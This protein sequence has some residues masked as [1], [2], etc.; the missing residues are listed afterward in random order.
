MAKS[1]AKS[2]GKSKPPKP[3]ERQPHGGALCRDGNP[4]NRGGTGRPPSILR[5]YL[6][7][8]FADRITV[9]EQ[10]ADGKTIQR[11]KVEGKET[12]AEISADV[13]DRLRA[14]DL[15]AKYGL[16]TLKEVSI[17]HVRERVQETVTVIKQH[18]S[19]D[20]AATILQALRPIWA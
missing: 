11:I 17:E 7:G 14:I 8:S 16:G 2:T 20:Q 6:R 4:G 13:S 5:D 18:T 15:L 19:P 1:T 3:K 10:I 9:L 12:G